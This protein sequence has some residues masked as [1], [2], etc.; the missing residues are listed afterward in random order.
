MSNWQEVQAK[1]KVMV[2]EALK[3]LKA[4]AEDAE[5][6]AGKTASAAKLHVA[7]KKNQ[8][9]RLKL[10]NELG[11]LVFDKADQAGKD[12]LSIDL[13]AKMKEHIARL[14]HLQKEIRRDEAK[15]TKFTVVKKK[16]NEDRGDL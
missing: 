16:K 10:L 1:A 12:A 4:G 3:I 15:L 6:I 14:R 11:S 5:I 7:I 8:V 2:E 9:T 13:T